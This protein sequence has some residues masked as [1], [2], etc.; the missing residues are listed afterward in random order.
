MALFVRKKHRGKLPALALN[1]GELRELLHAPTTGHN[2]RNLLRFLYEARA[3]HPDV[4]AQEYEP[5]A[6]A[7]LSRS[8][9]ADVRVLSARESRAVACALDT[10]GPLLSS[11][12]GDGLEVSS[13]A[14]LKTLLAYSERLPLAMLRISYGMHELRQAEAKEI[15]D[16][17]T[18][19]VVIRDL[20]VGYPSRDCEMLLE[21]LASLEHRNLRGLYLTHHEVAGTRFVERFVANPRHLERLERLELSWVTGQSALQPFLESRNLTGLKHFRFR[22]RLDSPEQEAVLEMLTTAPVLSQLESFGLNIFGGVQCSLHCMEHLL[23]QLSKAPLETL[24]L[25]TWVQGPERLDILVQWLN[26]QTTLKTLFIDNLSLGMEGLK[27]LC[28]VDFGPQFE[29]LHI[30]N[31]SWQRGEMVDYMTSGMRDVHF[32]INCNDAGFNKILKTRKKSDKITSY[33]VKELKLPEKDPARNFL[34]LKELGVWKN[35]DSLR[36]ESSMSHLVNDLI[37]LE[38][39]ERLRHLDMSQTQLSY[40][41]WQKF[42]GS[43]FARSGVRIE[44]PRVHEQADMEAEI[45]RYH[46]EKS[47]HFTTPQNLSLETFA[48]MLDEGLIHDVKTLTLGGR[49]FDT[50]LDCLEKHWLNGKLPNLEDVRF[51]HME[52]TVHRTLEFIHGELVEQLDLETRQWNYRGYNHTWLSGESGSLTLHAH[53]LRDGVLDVVERYH[54]QYPVMH[55][56]LYLGYQQQ[57]MF[58]QWSA[59]LYRGAFDRLRHLSIR[60]GQLDFELIERLISGGHLP[61]LEVLACAIRGEPEEVM[62]RLEG[63]QAFDHLSRVSIDVPWDQRERYRQWHDARPGARQ[64]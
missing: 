30:K 51:M 24:A 44:Q 26:E 37:E 52:A 10:W 28:E 20:E 36:I 34:I 46:Q 6:S 61:A 40:A 7:V 63:S 2:W 31:E 25:S 39:P 43:M 47:D 33:T 45:E 27:K 23:A 29:A 60:G 59:A 19:E 54:D 16:K 58:D 62:A 53:E 12:L 8:W 11:V 50:W 35:L 57:A 22:G 5:Y 15:V 42:K 49:V 21:H 18:S 41:T 9:P 56:V 64:E 13:V 38:P 17:L 48:W 55:L 4:F 32:D 14:T 3:N 1:F